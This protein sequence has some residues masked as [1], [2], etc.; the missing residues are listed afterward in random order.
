MS[1]VVDGL[2]GGPGDNNS[3]LVSTGQECL[4]VD[5]ADDA[6]PS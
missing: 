6:P 4:L 5:A 1:L 2:V 3:Y